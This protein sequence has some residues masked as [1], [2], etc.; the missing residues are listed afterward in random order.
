MHPVLFRIPVPNWNIPGIGPLH[1]TF[2]QGSIPIFSYGMML[3]LSLVI[4]WYLTLWLANKDGL[5]K[6]TMANCYVVTALSAL[7]G[8]RLLYVLTNLS[9]FHS[10]A[11]VFA[12]RNGGLVA[13]GGFLGG[14]LGSWAYLK[15]KHIP[16]LPWADIAVPSLASGLAVTRIGCYLFGCD[17]GKPLSD[18]AP[19]F[20]RTLGTFPHWEPGVVDRGDGAP[21]WVQHINSGL[22]DRTAEHSLPVHPTQLYESLLGLALL[23]LLLWQR[24]HQKFR[25]Q[26][27]LLFAFA[28][29]F[30]RFLLEIVRDDAERGSFGPNL[31]PHVAIGASLIAFAIAYCIGFANSIANKSVRIATQV[32]SFI[33]AVLAFTTLKP[34]S[35]AYASYIQLS[36]SQWVG[37][38]TAVAC[39]VAFMVFWKAAQAHPAQAMVIPLDGFYRLQASHAKASSDHSGEK[40]ENSDDGSVDEHAPSS[41][42]R[43]SQKGKKKRKRASDKS[44]DVVDAQ[45]DDETKESSSNSPPST[46]DDEDDEDA[47]QA[48]GDQHVSGE[49]IGSERDADTSDEH[50]AEKGEDAGE[51]EEIADRKPV[52]NSEPHQDSDNVSE[53]RDAVGTAA[54]PATKDANDSDSNEAVDSCSAP[55]KP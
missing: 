55:S 31:P 43:V 28:Y 27:F 34:S 49:K 25:G 40:D 4:G 53:N 45:F 7:V 11:D 32:A 38:L 39:G 24:K 6:E 52:A 48:S 20:L 23:A 29:G 44:S 14:Y 1:D 36:T 50:N 10:L 41:E 54:N 46:R 18:N 51:D 2:A 35:F 33:P 13:Y 47:D 26:V 15:S 17:F 5:P 9:E 21:A 16:L 19:G 3:G 12:F 37:V 30:V 22:I 42:E 8:S